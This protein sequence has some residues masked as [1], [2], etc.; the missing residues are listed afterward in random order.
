M[1][2]HCH[3][4]HSHS[5]GGADHDHEHDHSDDITPALQFS[6]YQHIN[7][8]EVVAYNET[9]EGSGRA[10]CKKSWEERLTVEPELASDADEQ[11]LVHIPYVALS[12]LVDTFFFLNSIF[13][14]LQVLSHLFA[15][16]T[17]SSPPLLPLGY[18][19]HTYSYA[20]G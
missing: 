20:A 10:I 18:V 8:D 1:S 3:D 5:H 13:L 4:E 9:A 2:H 15:L 19:Y 14:L 7:F 6:L 17:P 16:A 11:L 12:F